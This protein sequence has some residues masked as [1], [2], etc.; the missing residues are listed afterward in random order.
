MV[1]LPKVKLDG[2]CAKGHKSIFDIFGLYNIVVFEFSF[3]YIIRVG[4]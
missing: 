3:K 4:R 1:V 2:V